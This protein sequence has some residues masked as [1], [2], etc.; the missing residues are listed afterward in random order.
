MP[1]PSLTGLPTA[2]EQR[3]RQAETRIQTIREDLHQKT[4]PL[5]NTEAQ[6]QQLGHRKQAEGEEDQPTRRRNTNAEVMPLLGGFSTLPS[7]VDV[8]RLT[9]SVPCSTRPRCAPAHREA[10]QVDSL[11]LFTTCNS[12]DS[13]QRHAGPPPRWWSTSLLCSGTWRC[14][15]GKQVH[16]PNR[17]LLRAPPDY[18]QALPS[19]ASRS[20]PF[21]SGVQGC[22]TSLR[23]TSRRQSRRDQHT[24]T[25][26]HVDSPSKMSKTNGSAHT[27]PQPCGFLAEDVEAVRLR[28]SG[29]LHLDIDSM[30]KA[31]RSGRVRR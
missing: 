29:H 2:S 7:Y 5:G 23:I 25:A 6:H 31:S 13:T 20:C 1:L 17:R 21:H 15:C 12:T 4:Y 9:C 10:C 22:A 8:R 30:I 16:T 14:L 3:R 18:R 19:Q 27:Y 24:R 26:N 11:G 28:S